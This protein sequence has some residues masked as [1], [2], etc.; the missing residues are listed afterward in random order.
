MS[1][2][3]TFGKYYLKAIEYGMVAGGVGGSIY[4]SYIFTENERKPINI[5]GGAIVGASVGFGTGA[6]FT[7]A[8]II[9][10]PITIPVIG[11]KYLL[12][13]KQC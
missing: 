10:A 13:K 9:S 5:V 8:G 3:Q 4:G 7:G 12:D 6:L 1:K 11:T 2:L